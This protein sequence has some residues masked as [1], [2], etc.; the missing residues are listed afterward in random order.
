M[1]KCS[2]LCTSSTLFDW[3]HL[4][5]SLIF[6][7]LH[8]C[9]TDIDECRISPDLCGSGSCVNTPGSFE[10]ECFDGYES[11]FMMMKN[12]MGKCCQDDLKFAHLMYEAWLCAMLAPV[13]WLLHTYNY[14]DFLNK[15]NRDAVYRSDNWAMNT[16]LLGF[17]ANIT[18]FC[19]DILGCQNCT[20]M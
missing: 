14:C 1:A 18:H 3:I 19:I 5:L 8:Y 4:K 7:S 9:K 16:V 20:F 10:C 13:H 17:F 11:G 2:L 12:C 6:F 15:W